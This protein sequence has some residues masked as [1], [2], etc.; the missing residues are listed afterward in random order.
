MNEVICTRG[1]DGTVL[2]GATPRWSRFL[3][4]LGFSPGGASEPAV[5]DPDSHCSEGSPNAPP[6]FTVLG[7]G[8]KEPP[9]AGGVVA[10][11]PTAAN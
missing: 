4:G 7:C 11:T 9:R 6:G 10:V 3:A 8:Y 1:E 5:Q 2:E